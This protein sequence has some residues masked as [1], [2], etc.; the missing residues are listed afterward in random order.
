M[1]HLYRYIH[2]DV[3]VDFLNYPLNNQY[4]PDNDSLLGLM[5]SVVD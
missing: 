5:V 1:T 4:L 2:F 3:D